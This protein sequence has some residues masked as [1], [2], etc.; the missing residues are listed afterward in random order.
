LG[1]CSIPQD[2]QPDREKKSNL[3]IPEILFVSFHQIGVKGEVLAQFL[4]NLEQ[5][6]KSPPPRSNFY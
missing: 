1:L 3:N 2:N 4:I 6:K 5:Q